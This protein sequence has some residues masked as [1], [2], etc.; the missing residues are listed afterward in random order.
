MGPFSISFGRFETFNK[1]SSTDEFPEQLYF[2]AQSED[3]VVDA[4]PHEEHLERPIVMIVARTFSKETLRHAPPG[5]PR[6]PE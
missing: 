6:A 3:S 4:W 5:C 1:G 2:R